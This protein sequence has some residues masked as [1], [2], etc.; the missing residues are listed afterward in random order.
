MFREFYAALGGESLLGPAISK[1]F[2]Y[3]KFECQYTVNALICQDP[4]LSGESRFSLYPLGNAL[5]IRAEPAPV[6]PEAADLVVNG[7]TVFEEFIPVFDRLSGEGYA[8][9]PITQVRINY[10]QQRI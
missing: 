5:Q 3:D 1:I 10:T 9:N 6:D 4:L 7:Y 2:D 8:G